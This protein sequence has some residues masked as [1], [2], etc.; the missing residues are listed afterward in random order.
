[1]ADEKN[2]TDSHIVN[3][4][5]PTKAIENP[6]YVKQEPPKALAAA[7]AALDLEPNPAA[8]VVG[9]TG[10]ADVDAVGSLLADAAIPNADTIIK[11][12]SETGDVS[13]VNKA[14]IIEALGESVGAMALKQL[15][16]VTTDLN[17]KNAAART[18]VL[19]YANK[20]FNGKDADTT[21]AEIQTYVK[22]PESGFTDEE[23]GAMTKMLAAGGLQARLVIDNI[24][25]RY[26]SDSN[27]NIPADLLSGDTLVQGSFEPLSAREYSVKVDEATQKFGYESQEVQTLKQRRERSIARNLA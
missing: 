2:T 7:G 5:D 4:E 22:T 26:A 13:L 3:P 17:T 25:K 8:V 21:W 27:T 11:E 12:Y 16:S 10:H 1:M 24:A 6:D 23:R 9:K 20:S 14:A 19:D 15:E 18:E